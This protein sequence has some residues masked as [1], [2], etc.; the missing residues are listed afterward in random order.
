MPALSK[1]SLN[2]LQGVNPNLVKVVKRAIQI[3]KQDFTVIQGLRSVEEAYTNYGKGRTAAQLKTKGVPVKY[4]R[5]KEAKV[6]WLNNPLGSKHISGKAVD[7]CPYPIDW[8]DLDKFRLIADAMLKAA[9]ELGVHVS[10]GGTWKTAKDYPHFE[11][12]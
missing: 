2:R 12:S 9:K 11:I 6:T 4:A 8:D 1:T 7:L 3:T 10:W 5:P